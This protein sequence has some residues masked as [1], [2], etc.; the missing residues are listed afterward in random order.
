MK[1]IKKFVWNDLLREV[2]QITKKASD[3]SRHN[4]VSSSHK[5][6]KNVLRGQI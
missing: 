5:P 4:G 2:E 3:V 1:F 6:N